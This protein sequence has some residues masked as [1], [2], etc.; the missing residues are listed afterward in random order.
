MQPLT[1]LVSWITFK[2]LKNYETSFTKVVKLLQ[3]S[4]NRV[5]MERKGN[6][7]TAMVSRICQ[8]LLLIFYWLRSLMTSP[9][10]DTCFR[11]ADLSEKQETRLQTILRNIL[12][13]TSQ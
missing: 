6:R 8:N 5:L 11:V 2:K 10:N 9:I 12:P 3:V 7:R 1:V 4:M 13:S